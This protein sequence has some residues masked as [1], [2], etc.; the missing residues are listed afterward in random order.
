MV[1]K[2]IE[3]WFSQKIVNGR[4]PYTELNIKFLKPSSEVKN[5]RVLST[6]TA[7]DLLQLRP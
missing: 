3:L 7:V 5:E 4:I 6:V 1:A 2:A